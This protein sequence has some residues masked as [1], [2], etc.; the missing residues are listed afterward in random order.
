MDGKE[1]MLA[2]MSTKAKKKKVIQL[3]HVCL[4]HSIELFSFGTVQ[5]LTQQDSM[6]MLDSIRHPF[7]FLDSVCK[8]D[9]SLSE[10]AERVVMNE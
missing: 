6:A 1:A 9:M 5:I 4:S 10:V 3:C 2:C 7:M 8:L